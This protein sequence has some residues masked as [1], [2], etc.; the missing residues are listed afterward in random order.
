MA[1]HRQLPALDITIGLPHR[2][3]EDDPAAVKQQG[4]DQGADKATNEQE[5]QGPACVFGGLC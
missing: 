5:R 1:P 4:E 2:A 3:L